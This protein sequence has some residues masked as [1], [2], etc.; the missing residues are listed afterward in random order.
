V[1]SRWFDWLRSLFQP[2]PLDVPTTPTTRGNLG[3]RALDVARTQIGVAE[4]TGRNDGQQIARYFNGCTRRSK[5]GK[6]LPTGWQSGWDWCAAFAS[7][8]VYEAAKNGAQ[9]S[10]GRRITVWELIRDARETGAWQDVSAW[11]DGPSA[12]DLV[13]FRRAGDPRI[14]GQT[15][16]VSRCV[17]FDGG[18]LVTIGGNEI[19]QVREADVTFD[20]PRVVGVIRY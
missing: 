13:C 3:L 2:A 16:H 14:E 18:R 8:C 19:N 17:S 20:L 6:E 7:W 1:L 10:H 4:S 5:T 15:G 12:G 11:G 9:P